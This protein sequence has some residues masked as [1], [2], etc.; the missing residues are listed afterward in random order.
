MMSWRCALPPNPYYYAQDRLPRS[1]ERNPATSLSFL[2]QPSRAERTN[3]HYDNITQREKEKKKE[4]CM[5]SLYL[6]DI[7]LA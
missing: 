5:K 4:S 1:E 6:V 3:R 7:L 2:F